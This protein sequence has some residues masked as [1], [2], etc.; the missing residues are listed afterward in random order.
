MPK[1]PP[2]KS[3]GPRQR[4]I[5]CKFCRTRKLRCSRDS[6]CSNCLSR[7]IQCELEQTVSST[8]TVDERSR[9]ELLERIRKL[10][11]VVE[12]STRSTTTPSYPASPASILVPTALNSH[13]LGN[14]ND[15]AK[16]TQNGAAPS[17]NEQLDRDFAW[18]ESIYEGTDCAV[19]YV[20]C[21]IPV[22]QLLN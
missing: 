11:A 7:G 17:Q 21:C 3:G 10:E 20:N 5:S 8:S 1:E 4:P 22:L 16:E 2:N 9:S 14:F 6:P 13:V 15:T 19:S 12:Q 18:L